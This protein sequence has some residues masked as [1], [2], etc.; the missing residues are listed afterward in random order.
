M[1]KAQPS[2]ATT[3]SRISSPFSGKSSC[4]YLCF[5]VLGTHSNNKS[6][7]FL[8]QGI[9]ALPWWNIPFDCCLK[10]V[11]QLFWTIQI[12][13]KTTSSPLPFT[14][15]QC[16]HFGWTNSQSSPRFAQ[17]DDS[18]IS[19]WFSC[20]NLLI[21]PV[22]LMKSP[23]PE[24]ANKP[25]A[26][27]NW[28]SL[29]SKLFLK[30]VLYP[31]KLPFQIPFTS[32]VRILTYWV[33]RWFSFSKLRK[34]PNP[35]SKNHHHP[36]KKGGTTKW[37]FQLWKAEKIQRMVPVV[38]KS[39]ASQLWQFPRQWLVEAWAEG[40]GAKLRGTETFHW[41]RIPWR[42]RSCIHFLFQISIGISSSHNLLV[43]ITRKGKGTSPPETGSFVPHLAPVTSRYIQQY[44]VGPSRV[45][46][47][48]GK[49]AYFVH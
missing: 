46:L 32:Q 47:G 21:S 10:I 2:T 29:S 40:Q 19:S 33:S 37:L 16:S 39:Q 35:S 28:L 17:L 15:S 27:S 41:N 14:T 38:S 44:G 45:D 5:V 18:M 22:L 34:S 25:P 3:L 8:M 13:L 49:H 23:Y 12:V 30:D 1:W 26:Q 9:W 24:W 4:L 31:C 7:A 48:H 42:F 11:S 20:V 43:V 36:S 6:L